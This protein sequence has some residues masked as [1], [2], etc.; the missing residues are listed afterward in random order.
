M[1]KHYKKGGNRPE[2]TTVLVTITAAVNLA[3]ALIGLIK[4][5]LS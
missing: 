4:H 2:P 1:A 5:L 3:T